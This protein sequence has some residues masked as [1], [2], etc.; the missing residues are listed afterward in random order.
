MRGGCGQLQQKRSLS[1]G[2]HGHETTLTSYCKYGQKHN[3]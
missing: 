3:I 2:Y 1:R